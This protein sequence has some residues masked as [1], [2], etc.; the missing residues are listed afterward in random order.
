[1]SGAAPPPPHEIQVDLAATYSVA[2]FR[3]LPRIGHGHIGQYEFYVSL[4]GTN[5]GTPVATGSF[6]DTLAEKE[7]LFP[8]KTGRYI[9][10]RALTNAVGQPWTTIA[11][12]NVYQAGSSAAQLPHGTIDFPAAAATIVAGTTID[13]S[14]T[15][16]SAANLVPLTY[17]WSFQPGSGVDDVSIEDPGVTRFNYPGTFVATFTVADSLKRTD[18][19][20]PTRTI[21]VLPRGVLVSHAG[22]T[23]QYADSQETVGENGAATN[24]FDGL[25]ST[26]WHT[27]WLNAQPPPPHEIQ[28]N[29]GAPH[30]LNAFR[31]LP[32]QDGKTAGRISQY[33][34][35]VSS[36]GVNWTAAGNLTLAL[37]SQLFLGLAAAANVSNATINVQFRSFEATSLPNPVTSLT[38]AAIDASHEKVTWTTAGGA[39]SYLVQRKASTDTDYIDL[40][41]NASGTSFTDGTVSAGQTYAYGVVAVGSSGATTGQSATTTVM[42]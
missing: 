17:R 5:W 37:P 1:M 6:P 29:L 9:R 15:G 19:A 39:T 20:P 18:S 41:T 32:R 33:E 7:V 8:P 13:F 21:T 14:G 25:T 36:D 22:W 30:D 28:I 26:Y 3:Y 16:S 42:T 38:A 27:Q 11:E 24:A 4:D 31:Y 40:T 23:L 34:F 2:G 12:L 35:Y 10:F